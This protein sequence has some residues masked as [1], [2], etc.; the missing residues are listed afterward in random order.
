M[1]IRKPYDAQQRVTTNT[2]GKTRT[3]TQFAKEADI[4]HIMRRYE[5]TAILELS[6]APIEYG[7][8]PVDDYKTAIDYVRSVESDYAQLPSALRNHFGD[9]EGYLAFVDSD[10][11]L[12][13][14][15][16]S[17]NADRDLRTAEPADE[18]GTRAGAKP[19]TTRRN[20][21]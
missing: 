14:V 19:R 10:D 16:D 12:Q 8:R 2:T 15:W 13:T 5:K 9:I 18:V 4:N 1:K 3:Q 7:E 6:G 21:W 20:P 11:T 17:L